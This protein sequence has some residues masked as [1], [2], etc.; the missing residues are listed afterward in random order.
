[1]FGT[2]WRELC[3]F[4]LIKKGKKNVLRSSCIH[5][6]IMAANEPA[7]DNKI[8]KKDASRSVS[9]YESCHNFHFPFFLLTR[10]PYCDYRMAI[11]CVKFSTL[12]S[13]VQYA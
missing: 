9:I 4:L 7:D 8:E 11:L 5:L 13:N 6:Q 2:I 12:D 10:K 3:N 1:M